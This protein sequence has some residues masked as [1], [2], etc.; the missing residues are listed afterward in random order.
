MST[1]S[2]IAVAGIWIGVGMSAFGG[3]PEAAPL[4]ALFAFL[5]TCAVNA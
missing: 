3:A 5:A 2:G 4:I 1:G